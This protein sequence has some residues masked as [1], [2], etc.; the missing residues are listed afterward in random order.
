MSGRRPLVRR[1][2]PS[3]PRLVAMPSAWP[4][5]RVWLA[6]PPLDRAI[7]RGL[8]GGWDAAVAAGAG[9]VGEAGRPRDG[10]GVG[11]ARRQ[12]GRRGRR[13]AAAG[14]DGGEEKGRV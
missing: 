2:R 8:A 9:G 12:R 10:R 1:G 11:E 14:E 4:H 6:G 13:E 7:A 5:H 3:V